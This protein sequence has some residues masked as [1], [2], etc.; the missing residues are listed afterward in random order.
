MQATPQH[1]AMNQT[2]PEH[3]EVE[4]GSDDELE[5]L[6]GLEE[7]PEC[8]ICADGL[9]EGLLRLGC[10]H[11]FCEECIENQLRAR[12][13][14]SQMTF[15]YLNCAFCRAPMKHTWLETQL[16]VHLEL[17]E[18]AMKVAVQK[19]RDDGLVNEMEA[20]LHRLATQ[21][22]ISSQAVKEMAVFQCCDCQEPYCAGRMDCAAVQE[23]DVASSRC[24]DC[25][26][27]ATKDANDHRCMI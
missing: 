21:S 15:N 19:F 12:W 7:V 2:R 4:Q 5:D 24:P 13:P 22:E 18:R 6:P 27:V 3:M 9:E 10:G 17:Q 23:H 1:C 20:K 16:T 11:V 14:G 25:A 8:G 26:W